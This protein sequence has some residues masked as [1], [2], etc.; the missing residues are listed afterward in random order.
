[1]KQ[2]EIKKHSKKGHSSR[3]VDRESPENNLTQTH[4]SDRTERIFP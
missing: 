2:A 3:K 1:M 4:S